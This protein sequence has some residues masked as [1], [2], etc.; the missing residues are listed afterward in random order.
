MAVALNNTRMK[1]TCIALRTP[2]I[3]GL[4]ATFTAA[5]IATVALSAQNTSTW[6]FLGDDHRLH[7]QADAQGNRILDF[8]YAGYGGGGVQLPTVP[9]AATVGPS[10]A[11]D[12]AAIQAALDTVSAMPLDANGFRG[13]V[14]LTPGHYSTSDTL[15]ITASGVVLRGTG[16]GANGTYQTV[17]TMT[18]D[19]FLFLRISGTGSWQTSGTAVAMTDAYVPSGT[20]SFNVAD[21]SSF[22]PADTILIRRPVTAA[23][24]H[25]MGMDTLVRN[26]APQTWIAP[27]STITTDRTIA[28]INGNQIMLDVPL[29]DNFDQQFL[30]PPGGSVIAYS[31]P[32]RISQV[33]AEHLAIVAHPQNVDIT[34]PQFQGL[35]MNA[36]I[37]GWL[38]D[39][40]FL[41]TQNTM[42]ISS[43]VKQTTF[44]HISVRHTVAHTGDG[45]ADFA[46]SGTGLLFTKCSVTGRGGTWPAVTQSRVTGPDVLL[47]FRGDDRGFDPHQRWATGLLCDRCSFPNS[48]T[49]DKAGVAYSNRGILGSGQGWDAGWSVAWNTTST[50]FLIQQ[51]PGSQNFCI[52][53]TGTILTEAQ[54]GN[55]TPLLANGIYDS[56]GTPVTPSSLYLEQLCERLGPAAVAN[57][58][59]P[60][61]CAAP[62]TA[63]RSAAAASFVARR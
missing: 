61:T 49:S 25:L 59:Y 15:N 42:Q 6:I 32:G 20:T 23:W 14:L 7:Y 1:N 53:C 24:V 46:F 35:S 33:G 47:D 60:G 48:H 10:G 39:V 5:T 9:V 31:F 3:M 58:G 36:V 56:F 55:S 19:P 37:N 8:S 2:V 12:T 34:Q 4:F 52:G 27:G 44:D 41:D 40:V 26:G 50:Y 22:H 28:A 17:I 51:P 63:G 38:Q 43:S 16:S 18:G 54:P 21:A 30:N 45:P 11:D 62:P 57:I 13:A 29:T